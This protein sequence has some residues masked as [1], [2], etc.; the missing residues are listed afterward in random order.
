ME[1]G[2]WGGGV[3]IGGRGCAQTVTHP[4]CFGDSKIAS[5][6]S[7]RQNQELSDAKGA[8]NVHKVLQHIALGLLQQQSQTL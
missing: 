8:S 5:V 7:C 3:C 6:L 2:G 1:A 4:G